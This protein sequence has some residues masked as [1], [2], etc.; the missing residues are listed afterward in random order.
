[1]QPQTSLPGSEEVQMQ[2]AAGTAGLVETSFGKSSGSRL[3]GIAAGSRR[4][5]PVGMVMQGCRLG[6]GPT[7]CRSCGWVCWSFYLGAGRPFWTPR[8]AVMRPLPVA[9][10][11]ESWWWLAQHFAAAMSFHFAGDPGPASE[12]CEYLYL[13]KSGSSVQQDSEQHSP[14]RG[15]VSRAACRG[16]GHID[17]SGSKGWRCP[18]ASVMPKGGRQAM[19]RGAQAASDRWYLPGTRHPATQGEEEGLY[20]GYLMLRDMCRC[21]DGRWQNRIYLR[22]GVRPAGSEIELAF[23]GRVVA[24]PESQ[25][26][27]KGPRVTV[28][29]PATRWFLA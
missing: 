2:D 27:G 17:S 9:R 21:Q 14:A 11:R 8:H 13:R 5:G 1:M 16:Q 6:P 3:R 23:A 24:A 12:G 18:C 22:K 10:G 15:G 28:A 7:S 29:R 25:A 20:F 26:F 4:L 19:P